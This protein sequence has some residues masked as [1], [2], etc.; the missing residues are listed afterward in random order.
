[1]RV[2]LRAV[3]ISVCVCGVQHEVNIAKKDCEDMIK[4][5][6]DWQRKVELYASQEKQLQREAQAARDEVRCC[7][8]CSCS[9][10]VTQTRLV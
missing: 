4:V 8:E 7:Q 1:V 9:S 2:S 10:H 6:Q 5:M 3:A